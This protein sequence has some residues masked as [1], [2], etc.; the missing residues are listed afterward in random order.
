MNEAALDAVRKASFVVTNPAHYAVALAW[1]EETMEAP[2]L[3]AKGRD[4]LARRMMEESARGGS[5]AAQRAPR[6]VAARELEL[7]E[8]VPE[9]LFDAVAGRG[10]GVSRRWGPR[11]G[12]R[13]LNCQPVE[14]GGARGCF[15]HSRGRHSAGASD[16]WTYTDTR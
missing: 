8:P 16:T 4:G 2:E 3:L 14:R 15:V 1:D 5:G 13:A 7:R 10:G 11:R 6:A 9:A 12:L